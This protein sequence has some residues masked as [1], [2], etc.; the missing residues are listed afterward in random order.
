MESACRKYHDCCVSAIACYKSGAEVRVLSGDHTG[1]LVVSD[2]KTGK[3]LRLL[4]SDEESFS[5]ERVHKG[6]IT[7][8]FAK[9]P[10]K[11][12]KI[13]VVTSG[14]DQDVVLIEL[15][16]KPLKDSSDVAIFAR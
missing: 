4:S 13:L 5:P 8:I 16:E 10:T 15:E 2:F 7:S 9:P 1:Q 14:L 3:Q 11:D 12:G 6:V